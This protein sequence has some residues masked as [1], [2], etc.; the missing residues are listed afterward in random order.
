M[1]IYIYSCKMVRD[2]YTN[3]T[4]SYCLYSNEP[5]ILQMVK[6]I[7]TNQTKQTGE[8]YWNWFIKIHSNQIVLVIHFE[9]CIY[10]FCKNMPFIESV[11]IVVFSKD[12]QER[13]GVERLMSRVGS[14]YQL[15]NPI[16]NEK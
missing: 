14:I 10:Y 1:F 7:E 3:L 13:R 16:T 11:L 5:Y 12:R 2:T 15:A 8:L 4:H 9:H 6:K